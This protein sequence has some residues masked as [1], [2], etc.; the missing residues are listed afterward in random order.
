[1]RII[2]LYTI[3]FWFGLCGG[4]QSLG[5]VCTFFKAF[6]AHM[7]SGA[8]G[9]RA[10]SRT[11]LTTHSNV[12]LKETPVCLLQPA[13]FRNFS[14]RISYGRHSGAAGHRSPRAR[15]NQ[16]DVHGYPQWQGFYKKAS[17]WRQIRNIKIIL[18]RKYAMKNDMT[19]FIK[20]NNQIAY[21]TIKKIFRFLNF[22][23]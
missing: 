18:Y 6:G 22:F 4:V 1:M 11:V 8:F 19:R 15:R 21:L 12:L 16:S 7:A 10:F 3:N 9:S 20:G 5:H 17:H 23:K 13:L 2:R 14:R